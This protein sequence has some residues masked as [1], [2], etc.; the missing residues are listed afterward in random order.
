[1]QI[2]GCGGGGDTGSVSPPPPTINS[3]TVACSP[4]A[5]LTVETSTCTANVTGTGSYNSAVTWSVSP[6]GAGS[7]SNTGVFTPSS[8]GTTTITA[9]STQDTAKSGSAPISVPG[10]KAL[11]LMSGGYIA[12][13]VVDQ[14]HTAFASTA[15]T[16]VGRPAGT[17]GLSSPG[18]LKTK[19]HGATWVSAQGNLPAPISGPFVADP[20][21]P[22]VLYAWTSLGL[23]KTTN[24]GT[25]WNKLGLNLPVG[26]AAQK[27]AI[28][29]TNPNRIYVSTS[30]AS[31]QCSTDG[32]NTWTKCSNGLYGGSF[33]PDY[34]T[35]IAVSPTNELV[36]YTATYRGLLFKTIDGGANWQAIVNT[37]Y[38]G[39]ANQ[40]YIALSNP[41]VLYLLAAEGYTGG[42]VEKSV[43]GGNTWTDAGIPDGVTGDARQLQI[44]PS[45][46]N[47]VY[48]TTSAGL[49]E[50]TQGGG[51]WKQV[52]APAQ[53]VPDV[54]SVALD[55]QNSVIYAGTSVSGVYRSLDGGL[56]WQQVNQGIFE[57]RVA[58]L[59]VCSSA[60]NTIYAVASGQVPI[61]STDSG[62]TWSEVGFTQINSQETACLACNPANPSILLVGSEYSSGAGYVRPVGN[63][64]ISNDG[65]MT[66]NTAS[67]SVPN[68]Q[69]G[70][71]AFNPLNPS[72][73]NASLPDWQGGFLS[74]ADGGPTWTQP[75]S[76]YTY[77]ENY[78]YHPT[79]GN[80]VFTVTNTYVYGAQYDNLSVAY[81]VDSGATWNYFQSGQGFFSY[82]A[83]DQGDPTVLYVAGEIVSEGSPS[84]VYKYQVAY[85]GNQITSFTRVPGTFNSGLPT[86]ADIRQLLF[87]KAT[88]YLYAATG[89]G[90]FRSKD[91][92]A[93][94]AS[95]NQD[96]LPYL[97]ISRI[98]I[99]PD[100]AHLYAGTNGGIYELDVP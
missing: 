43:D 60:P 32:G 62:A 85:N 25:N 8:T 15:S 92:A 90:I 83:L 75:N 74:S 55:P 71:L 2:V 30:L 44:L 58:G 87:N 23:Y 37:P 26:D 4:K 41:N 65:G 94:W 86:N 14:G 24:E 21:L 9:S 35:A 64:W 27:I 39:S 78:A 76:I 95:V 48:A 80:I 66:F 63:I 31:V 46:P 70:I 28:A 99:S 73:V 49:Y 18:I 29:P 1:M 7:I 98:A 57:V 53:G 91:G 36:A 16:R 50:T 3:V 12:S 56:T 79:L 10:W 11:K 100:G 72:L 22:G 42:T 69:A 33:G 77:P 13:L 93:T 59:D 51:I 82:V 81:S 67:V 20:V 47:T 34:V 6:T 68:V 38:V 88:G 52:F 5:I 19:D 54:V 45:D 97:D 84:G 89:S 61:K 17:P 96:D 40:I